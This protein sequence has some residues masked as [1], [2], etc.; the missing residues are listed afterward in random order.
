MLENIDFVINTP[1]GNAY[2]IRNADYLMGFIE[3]KNKCFTLAF[4]SFLIITSLCLFSLSLGFRR[5]DSR[6]VHQIKVFLFCCFIRSSTEPEVHSGLEDLNESIVNPST[7]VI[8]ESSILSDE[9]AAISKEV[10][11]DEPAQLNKPVK[12]GS[13][14]ENNDSIFSL[15]YSIAKKVTIVGVIYFV[16]YMNWSVAWLITPVILAVTREFWQRESEVRRS[17]AK[18]CATANEK[19][20]ILARINDL[21]A[22]VNHRLI[23]SSR[24]SDFF[25]LVFQFV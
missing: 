8:S 23:K 21:P 24:C 19:D 20:V 10:S 18:A 16:G 13:S 3:I 6:K 15:L 22:W 1:S 4:R 5:C 25:Y 2:F 9:M 12:N 7:P 11:R 14:S 17:I